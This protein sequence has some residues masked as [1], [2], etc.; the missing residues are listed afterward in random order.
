MRILAIRL[1]NLNSLVGSWVIDFTVPEFVASGIFAVTGPTG[2]GKSTILDAICLALF[3]RTPRLGH[4]SKGS[5]EIMARRTG[6]CFAEVDFETGQGS[7]RCH[8]GQHRARRHSGG[9]LQAPRHE[10][11]DLCTGRVLETRSKEVGRLV[12]EATGMDYERFT[13]SILLAQGDF[14]AFLEAEADQRAPLLEQITGTGLYSRISIAVHERTSAERRTTAVLLEDMGRVVVL[15]EAEERKL[16][17]AVNEDQAAAVALG[18]RLNHLGRIVHQQRTIALL[19]TQLTE[20]DRLLEDLAHRRQAAGDDLIRFDRGRRAQTLLA[21]YAQWRQTEERLGMLRAREADLAAGLERLHRERQRLAV[22]HD[23][24]TQAL[25]EK[26]ACRLR[27]AETITAIRALDLLLHEKRQAIKQ[28]QAVLR[29]NERE[30]DEIL[31]QLHVQQQR[32]A[33][34]ADQQE[35]L[36]VFFR[37]HGADALL[38]EHLA[39]FRRQLQQISAKE[40]ALSALLQAVADRSA[41]RDKARI[42]ADRLGRESQQAAEQLAV[43]QQR[44]QEMLTQ[45]DAL[46]AGQELFIWRRHMEEEMERWRQLERAAELLTRQQAAEAEL[47]SL[48]QTRRDLLARELLYT[49]ELRI[50]EE[51]RQVREHLLHRCELA[52]QLRTRISTFTEERKQLRSGEPCP[53]C[54]ATSHPWAEKQPATDDESEEEPSVRAR[55]ELDETCAAVTRVREALAGLGKDRE[56]NA[57]AMAREQRQRDEWAAQLSSLLPLFG[58]AGEAARQQAQRTGRM[59]D[60]RSRVQAVD[61]LEDELLAVRVQTEQATACSYDLQRRE[62]DAR[63]NVAAIESDVLRMEQQIRDEQSWMA[64][65]RADLILQLRPLGIK[66]CEPGQADD[67]L[68]SLEDRLQTWKERQAHDTRLGEQR[69]GLLAECDKMNLLLATIDKSM[70]Q[71]AA[72]LA[73]MECETNSLHGQRCERYGDRDPDVEEQRLHVEAQRAM[74]QERANRDRLAE[75]DKQ[76]HGLK[77]Q[78]RLNKEELTTLTTAGQTQAACLFDLLPGAGFIG[79]DDFQ[80]ALLPSAELAVLDTLKQELDRE[81]AALIAR[82]AEQEKSLVREEEQIQ[83]E[84]GREVLLA[85]QA[86]CNRAMEEV[87]QRIGANRERLQANDRN[88]RE[89]MDRQQALVVQQREQERWD[90]LHLLIGSADGKK[91]RVF[92]QGLTFEVMIS[93]ANRQL[94]RMSDRYLLLHDPEEPL[95]LQ[96]IDNY[97]AGEIRSTR[98]LSGGESFLVSLAMALGLSAMGSHTVQVDSLFLD[99][100]FGTLDEESLE[101]ALHVLADL[102]Q[103]GKLIGIISHVPLLRDRIDVRIQVQPGPNGTS[104]LLGPGCTRLD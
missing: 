83:D 33:E 27:E 4:I 101:S 78:A 81:Q 104:S 6:D 54:G 1:R 49:D 15:D 102:R 68:R 45:R 20:T 10:I 99:E 3:A 42:Q 2:A 82:R 55:A 77:E 19:R 97:Q 103:D 23:Q 18:E 70:A 80:S 63:Q 38:V 40:H 43:L 58:D 53:L 13:R 60:L 39:G 75:A 57:L 31:R 52:R 67:L 25:E 59:E 66:T 50:Y 62:Q 73:E 93:H 8:W 44:Q 30:R 88:R 71:Q 64:D 48:E 91:F 84:R 85:E 28:T 96:V 16:S 86:E 51:Q 90:L 7:F 22:D 32:L 98:N 36:A 87:Q 35:Q 14:A 76:I 5:N 65:C 21:E 94:R 89:C 34:I 24:A 9:E 29:Q 46:L 69:A 56:H 92:A 61:R 95:A 79:V 74:A 47:A 37:D 12:E 100:G 72:R 26:T 17:T 11:V 41:A